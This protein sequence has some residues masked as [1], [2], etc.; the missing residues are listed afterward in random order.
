LHIINIIDIIEIVGII[1]DRER[2]R[3]R[4]MQTFEMSDTNSDTGM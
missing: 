1:Y 2:E 4:E 3:E